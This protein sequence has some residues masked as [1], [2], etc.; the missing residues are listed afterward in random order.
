MRR[1]EA[2]HGCARRMRGQAVALALAAARGQQAGRREGRP[3]ARGA[4]APAVLTRSAVVS[5]SSERSTF[6][7]TSSMCARCACLVGWLVAETQAEVGRRQHAQRSAPPRRPRPAAGTARRAAAPPHLG[8]AEGAGEQRRV[9][10]YAHHVEAAP[11]E[12]HAAPPLGA[13]GDVDAHGVRAVAARPREQPLKLVPQRRREGVAA[14]EGGGGTGAERALE[15]GHAASGAELGLVM[16]LP[17][18]LRPPPPSP[19][20]AQHVDKALAGVVALK[21]GI[22]AV[23][24]LGALQPLLGA[25]CGTA[26]VEGAA[27]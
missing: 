20:L 23:P 19:V 5:C 10:L 15:A 16:P 7:V 9:C 17:S 12:L 24:R 2:Q 8:K 6:A 1:H 22:L 25:H 14:A 26:A 27:A 3:G 4:P 13:D 18:A 11:R 21:D